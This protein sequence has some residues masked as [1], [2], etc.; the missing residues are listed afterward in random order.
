MNT[1]L[2]NPC[3]SVFIRGLLFYGA[4]VML[5][6]CRSRMPLGAGPAAAGPIDRNATPETR[7]LFEN[8]RRTARQSRV[9]F[10][11]Q[12]DLAY[13]YR[14]FAEVGRSDVKEAAGAYP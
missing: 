11:H 1:D 14:W 13:G 9:L 3:R 10:G 2:F 5:A 7:A 8:L 6:G 4:I 12:D